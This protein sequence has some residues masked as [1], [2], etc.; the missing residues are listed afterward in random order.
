MKKIVLALLI[1]VVAFTF[2]GCPKVYGDL[3]IDWDSAEGGNDAYGVATIDTTK[4]KDF[5]NSTQNRGMRFLNTK[6]ESFSCKVK[7]DDVTAAGSSVMGLAFGQE[8]VGTYEFE[9]EKGEKETKKLQDFALAGVNIGTDG[10]VRYYVSVFRNIKETEMNGTNFSVKESSEGVFTFEDGEAVEF[11]F[12]TNR[13]TNGFTKT[14]LQAAED[15][16]FV[17]NIDIKQ[18]NGS[19]TVTFKDKDQGEVGTVEIP[20]NA[21]KDRDGT[22]TVQGY[23]GFYANVYSNTHLKGSWTVTDIEGNPIPL[24]WADTE[25][26]PLIK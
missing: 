5:D 3:D 7:F 17:M 13:E 22:K 14:N 25:A 8:D 11:M 1:A 24:E 18:E 10:Y 2:V 6:H 9:N 12:N 21:F 19:Y 26:N 23:T 16:T 15:G 20:Y 4:Q